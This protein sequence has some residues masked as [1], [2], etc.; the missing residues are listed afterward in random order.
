MTPD[1]AWIVVRH[2][3]EVPCSV[4]EEVFRDFE[5]AMEY[6]NFQCS[7]EAAKL[8]DPFENEIDVWV[9]ANGDMPDRQYT[10]TEWVIR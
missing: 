1:T 7:G 3:A 8:T 10:I 5:P 2:D 6:V 9:A 4:V